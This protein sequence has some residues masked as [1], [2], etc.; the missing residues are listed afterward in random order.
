MLIKSLP[1]LDV[2]KTAESGQCF[3]FIE[4][5]KNLFRLI[6]FNKVLFIEL[7]GDSKIKFHC[8]EEEFNSIW[9]KYF[10]LDTNYEPWLHEPK[11]AFM[12]SAI[13]DG[14]GIRML[15]QDK[16]ETLISFIISQR[17]NIPAIQSSIEKLSRLFGRP[18]DEKGEAFSFPS[19]ERLANA[20][21]DE[22]YSCSLGYRAPYILE[23][24]RAISTLPKI[25][26][27]FDFL[28]DEELLKTLMG[29]KGVGIKV[30]SCT[31]LFSY[32]RLGIFPRDVW[33]LRM[34]RKHYDGH[35]P[36]ENYPGFAGLLQQYAFYEMRL[37]DK[38]E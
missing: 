32:H 12:K 25:L 4:V 9:F 14:Y 38:R 37:H 24:S 23:T 7:L 16:F 34:E 22:L 15:R 20:S 6:A 29:F 2:L 17:K 8:S 10:D 33:I 11:D 1:Q 36:D 35:F 31:A 27:D 3:R 21:L 26:D 5:K 19:P 30:A 28:S 18:L 13:R